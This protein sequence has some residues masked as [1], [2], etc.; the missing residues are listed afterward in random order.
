MKFEETK[1]PILLLD[2]PLAHALS[3]SESGRTTALLPRDTAEKIRIN[4]LNNS[5]Q[6]KPA[7][8]NAALE[9]QYG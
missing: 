1:E 6:N 9:Y 8:F 4:R 3:T 7:E 5:Y 2:G